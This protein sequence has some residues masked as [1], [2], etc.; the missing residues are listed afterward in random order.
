M[1]GGEDAA[2]PAAGTAALQAPPSSLVFTSVTFGTPPTAADTKQSRN[3]LNPNHFPA[4][5]LRQ[6]IR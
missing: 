4:A 3:P 2:S 1:R 5:G 6:N